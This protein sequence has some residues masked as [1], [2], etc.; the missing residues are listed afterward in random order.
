MVHPRLLVT[1]SSSRLPSPCSDCPSRRPE[2]RRPRAADRRRPRSWLVAPSENTL[3]LCERIR[4]AL[5]LTGRF[6]RRV[7]A[8]TFQENL[9]DTLALI[10]R[11][12][13]EARDVW[14]TRAPILQS[15]R[16]RG[17]IPMCP[18]PSS[19]PRARCFPDA[20]PN[21]QGIVLRTREAAFLAGWLAAKLEARRPGRDV[22]GVVGGDQDAVGRRTSSVGFAAGAKRAAPAGQGAGRLLGRLH[23]RVAVRGAR[24]PADRAR[25]GRRS[26]TSRAHAGSGRSPPPPTLASGPSASTATSR[27]SARTS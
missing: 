21:V 10:A 25:G 19:M 11:Q 12:G 7:V 4:D 26:S 2:R 23:G 1:A 24:P 6:V 9:A 14:G 27:S 13:Y 16:S 8:P 22:I 18:S 20:P 5:R 3:R 15:P 17:D